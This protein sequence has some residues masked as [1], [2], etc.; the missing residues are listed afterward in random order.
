MPIS[1]GRHSSSRCGSTGR[2][3]P[4]DET[5]GTPRMDGEIE[6]IHQDTVEGTTKGGFCTTRGSPGLDTGSRESRETVAV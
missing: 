1:S 5:V 4:T 6:V 3:Y 2:E